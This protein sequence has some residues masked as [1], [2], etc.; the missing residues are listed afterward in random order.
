MIRATGWL[1]AVFWLAACGANGA[2]DM[3]TTESGENGEPVA[4]DDWPEPI[5]PPGDLT[6][7][8]GQLD[9]AQAIDERWERVVPAEPR[10]LSE[11]QTAELLARLEPLPEQAEDQQEFALRPGSQPPPRAGNMIQAEFPP[12]AE[13]ELPSVEPVA[14]PLRLLRFSPEGEVSIA[15]QISLT[16]DRPMVAVS[17]HD[18]IGGAPDGVSIEPAVEGHWRWAGTRTLLFEPEAA[19]L[20]M[21][22]EFRVELGSELRAADGAALETPVSFAFT[23]PALKWTRLHP[24]GEQVGLDPVLVLAFNQRIAPSVLTQ[25]IE[26]A[27]EQGRERAFVPADEADLAADESARAFADRLRAGHWL[28]LKLSETLPP[29]ER[30]A[31]RL[32]ADA[33][34]A[35]GPR[36]ANEAQVESFRTYPP[37]VVEE[38]RCGWNRGCAPADPIRVR[39]SSP[40]DSDQALAEMVS[41]EP[42]ILGLDVQAW[43][44]DL[45]I[46][47][48]KRGRTSHRVVLAPSL[49]DTFGQTL[50]GEREF[51][52]RVGSAPARLG[53]AVEQLTTL[54]PLSPPTLSFFSTNYRNVAVRIHRVQPS[55]WPAYLAVYRGA[56]RR[57][58]DAV[59][60][61]GEP[62]FSGPVEIEAE[63]DE[64]VRTS[65]DLTPYL[66]DGQYGHLVVQFEPGARVEGAVE[67]Y[68]SAREMTWIQA[69]DIGI[70]ASLD[71]R[72]LLVW[73]TELGTGRPLEGARVRVDESGLQGVSDSAGLVEFELPRADDDVMAPQWILVEQ[74]DDRALLPEANHWS[75]RTT[76]VRRESND[77]VLWHTFDDRGVYRP[78]ERVH[79]KGWL[80]RA[81]QRPDGGLALL[82]DDSAIAYAVF[83][84]RNNRLHEGRAEVGALGGFELAFDLPDTPNLGRAR[85][86]LTLETGANLDNASYG[87]GFAIEEFRTPEFEVSTR[88]PAGPHVGE[89][90]VSVE[91][92]AAYYAGGALPGAPVRWTVNARPGHYAPPGHPGWS[93]G[94]TS[95]GWFPFG[96][97]GGGSASLSY[98]GETDGGGRHAL[99]VALDFA[100]QP[101][102][103]LVEATAGV[104]D[105]N[106]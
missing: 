52:I 14:G 41:V 73:A 81:E 72:R 21:A 58:E 93:F 6:E 67:S 97:F 103:L 95:P 75:S 32:A 37:F 5:D 30:I 36:R 56:W 48:L 45:V 99:D 106:R 61:P 63:P 12:A 23:T 79:L 28:A 29:D 92:Q 46:G 26:I 57:A 65:I 22:T 15:G 60:L 7:F 55:D 77:R 31:V 19:R 3:G 91:V 78:G 20:P 16:F 25:F 86:D 102:P 43:G 89:T 51:T 38:A 9:E 68:S 39:F 24:Q 85:I 49:V 64:T 88:V 76:W 74:G 8:P 47:G 35:E 62:V 1:L 98:E 42:E 82:P 2:S 83:D 44:S 54:D 94:F 50:T 66:E 101:R 4:A 70:D 80:R 90:P 84:S 34:S 27:D 33:P 104:S 96:D 69:T 13:R 11:E 71:A 10:P 17:S 59:E 105:V 100:P 40:L 53:L 87:H 18:A